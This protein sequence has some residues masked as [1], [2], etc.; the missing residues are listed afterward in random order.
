[1]NRIRALELSLRTKYA[2]KVSLPPDFW[3]YPMHATLESGP[4]CYRLTEME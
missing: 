1:M 3:H 2:S 4:Q